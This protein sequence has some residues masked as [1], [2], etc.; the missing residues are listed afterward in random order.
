MANRV[1]LD[2]ESQTLA[3]ISG[4]TVV[5]TAGSF[6]FVQNYAPGIGDPNPTYAL[7]AN[8]P[9]ALGELGLILGPF[10][11]GAMNTFYMQMAQLLVGTTCQMYLSYEF[12]SKLFTS[13]SGIASFFYDE[14][15]PVIRVYSGDTLGLDDALTHDE[16]I[17]HRIVT[18]KGGELTFLHD[19][20]NT[21]G[22]LEPNGVSW[23]NGGGGNVTTV[24]GN[25]VL[26]HPSYA[27]NDYY[28]ALAFVLGA[29][30]KILLDELGVTT[31]GSIERAPLTLAAVSAGQ[32]Q[33][34]ATWD[35]N[36]DTP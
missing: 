35:D 14:A 11:S 19:H 34:D 9:C 5:N 18:G 6:D 33:I 28:V 17:D 10:S 30:D 26:G 29:N 27:S 21:P 36:E 22:R 15:L 1:F 24:S 12:S 4:L 7:R 2:F 31:Q 25:P 32:T 8:G 3:G 13:T 23:S 20:F 16:W